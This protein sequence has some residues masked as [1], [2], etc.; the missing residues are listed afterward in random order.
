MKIIFDYNRTIY[1]P[2]E[3]ALYEGVFEVLDELS[4]KHELY[5]VSAHEPGRREKIKDFGIHIFF[6]KVFFVNHKAV[7]IFKLIA[8][9]GEEVLVVGDNIYSEINVGN[10]MNFNTVLLN[11]ENRKMFP[12]KEEHKQKHTINHI[13]GLKDILNVYN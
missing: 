8:N 13:F 1:N 11:H 7:E 2:D 6:K 9:E 3:E 4:K 5:L 10:K 12:L